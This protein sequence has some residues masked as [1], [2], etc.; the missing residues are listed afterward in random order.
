M[1]AYFGLEN[2]PVHITRIAI[3][4]GTIGN[5]VVYNELPTVSFVFVIGI[6]VTRNLT[7]VPGKL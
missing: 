7:Q 2:P 4:D 3:G 5:D 6:H 1:K